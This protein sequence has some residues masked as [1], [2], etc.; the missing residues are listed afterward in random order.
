[1]K[2]LILLLVFVFSH[3]I[4]KSQNAP[5]FILTDSDTIEHNLYE[6]Y[7]DKGKIVVIKMFF[8]A[9]PICKPYN[10]PFQTLYEEFGSGQEGVEFFL[11]TTHSNDSNEEIGEYRQEYGL[12]FPGSGGDGGGYAATEPYRSGD[13]GSF[14]G[15]PTF[16]VIEPNKTVHFDISASGVSA[17]LQKVK[18]K[19]IE[20]QNG[21]SGEMV[22]T[23]IK[24][25]VENYKDLPL[26]SYSIKMRSGTNPDSSYTVPLEFTYPSQLYPKL[27]SPEV[28]LEIEERS[29]EGI[30]TID[31][32][33]IQRN[34]LGIYALD[35]IQ[36]LAGDVNGSGVLTPSDLLSMRKVIL[37][38]SD[39]FAVDRS[40]LSI[41]KR[42]NEDIDLCDESI[43]IDVTQAEQAINFTIIK[44]GD[45]K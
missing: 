32:L 24:I 22:S 38:I 39:G 10:A 7:L 3:Q 8:V 19:I 34:I 26:P 17:T 30:T 16:I 33:L 40:Y 9:C 36:R 28:Y 25:T 21:G 20:I 11:L 42:C 6:D 37:T 13:Y 4:G 45:I 2:H 14:F 15:S 18:D 1:M 41:D 31:L 5:N 43:K 12:T 44:F 27:S 35:N 29:N 23:Q